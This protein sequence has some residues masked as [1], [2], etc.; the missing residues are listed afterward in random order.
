MFHMKHSR[1]I[2]RKEGTQMQK[3]QISS[4]YGEMHKG[5][6]RFEK[7]QHVTIELNHPN[8]YFRIDVSVI[9]YKR[10]FD[11]DWELIQE[12]ARTLKLYTDKK[13]T[14]TSAILNY[15]GVFAGEVIYKV[16]DDLLVWYNTTNKHG[17]KVY[18]V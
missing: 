3:T 6:N 8:N 7:A 12:V 10:G 16:K 5:R 18:K 13:D 1:V 14:M 15:N 2:I 9:D 17:K 11:V 4:I